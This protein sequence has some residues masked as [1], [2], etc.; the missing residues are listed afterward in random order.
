VLEHIIEQSGKHFDPRI[1]DVFLK[2]V[3][4]LDG[5]DNQENSA[6]SEPMPIE[7]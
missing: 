5:T 2:F 6:R 4:K 3:K 1:V 7:P